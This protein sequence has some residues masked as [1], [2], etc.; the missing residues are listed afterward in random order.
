MKKDNRSRRI[1]VSATIYGVVLPLIVLG[2]LFIASQV[3]NIEFG[4][5]VFAFTAFTVVSLFA[6]MGWGRRMDAARPTGEL[7]RNSAT[8]YGREVS[9]GTFTQLPLPA[10][11]LFI[12]TGTTILGWVGLLVTM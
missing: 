1:A 6:A 5:I 8:D 9:D 12:L 3:T 2:V 10:R 11:A 7:F 4:N